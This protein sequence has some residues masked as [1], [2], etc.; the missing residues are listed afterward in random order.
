ML[1]DNKE[2]VAYISTCGVELES[3][4]LEKKGDPLEEFVADAIKL[5]YLY[6]VQKPFR[7]SVK[8]DVFKQSGYLASLN[9]GSLELWPISEQK[10]LFAML[11][12]EPEVKEK[13]GVT[14]A[15]SFLMC[16]TKSTS[17]ILFL[18]E[19]EYENCELCPRLTCPNR[20]A[21]FKGE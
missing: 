14:L 19:K 20:R 9:P 11:G 15:E 6:S 2:V 8:N 10:N 16:P 18:S 21:K 5:N 3:W 1:A 4:S 13:I 7:E 12:G 17:G